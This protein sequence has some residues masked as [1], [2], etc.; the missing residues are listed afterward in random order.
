MS[1]SKA[2]TQTS[3]SAEPDIQVL[4]HGTCPTSSGKSTLGYEVG[5]DESDAIHVRISSNDGGGMFSSE[6][7]SFTDIQASLKAWPADQGVTSNTF[8]KIFRG[9]SANTPGFLIAVLCVEGIIE[10]MGD[11]KRVHQACDPAVFVASMETLRKSSA[12]GTSKKP[13]A[14]ATS[15]APAKEKPATKAKAKTPATGTDK[16]AKTSGKSAAKNPKNP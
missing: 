8:R 12:G 3:E 16:T 13:A 15:K 11:K 14:K 9:K 5:T 2:T 6:W 1:K 7:V 4:K 10:P